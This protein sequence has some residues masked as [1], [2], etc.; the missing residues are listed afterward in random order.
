M[1]TTM[2][3]TGDL[4]AESTSADPAVGLRAVAALRRLAEQLEELQVAGARSRGWS[5]ADIA[6]A[7]GVSKQAVHKKYSG[8]QP[9]G[10]GRR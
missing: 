8:R 2:T 10:P 6:A 5:W 3:D 9:P 7:I 1:L 4:V